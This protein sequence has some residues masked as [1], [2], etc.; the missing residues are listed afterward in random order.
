MQLCGCVACNPANN[1][2][3]SAIS[4]LASDAETASTADIRL[5]AMV[6]DKASLCVVTRTSVVYGTASQ[7]GFSLKPSVNITVSASVGIAVVASV[8]A[9]GETPDATDVVQSP[10]PNSDI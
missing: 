8:V 6:C 10:Y 2:C 4:S 9:A 7:K 3:C 5:F 1:V